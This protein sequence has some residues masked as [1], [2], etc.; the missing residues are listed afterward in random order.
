MPAKPTLTT[1]ALVIGYAMS[2]LDVAYLGGRDAA[3]WRAA[4][5]EAASR[6]GSPWTTFKQL[7]DEFDPFHP[8]EREG[9]HKRP[10]RP[11]RQR[12][13]DDLREV[14]D[15]A[16]LALVDRILAG[17]TEATAEA[18]ESLT[19]GPRTAGAVAERLLT[20][21]R[22][23]RFFLDHSLALIGHPREGLLDKRIDAC[24]YDFGVESRAEL[25]IEVKG[26]KAMA[27]EILF[28]DREWREAG[29]RRGDYLLV[30]VGGLSATPRARVIR[31][32]V[33]NLTATPS[34]RVTVA[35][36][37]SSR[38]SAAVSGLH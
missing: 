21:Q 3:T 8:N 16:L 28:T 30:V 35:T 9:W 5:R 13:L 26:L 15:E 29:S 25:A 10:L 33:G 17:D 37:W 19:P 38:V 7:R 23:E 31:D 1:E 27:G 11:D 4:F 32:P 34:L 18:I 36:V 14:E 6:M 20:G 22:A 2:R 24:G 12:V